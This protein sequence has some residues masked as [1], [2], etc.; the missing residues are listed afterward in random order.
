MEYGIPERGVMI[1]L[2]ALNRET[3][4]AELKERYRLDLKKAARDKLNREGLVQS[5]RLPEPRASPT[6]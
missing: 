1:A 5:R 2:M 4:N 6:S 3:R